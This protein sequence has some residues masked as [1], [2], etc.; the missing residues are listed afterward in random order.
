MPGTLGVFTLDPAG[1][2]T[3]PVFIQRLITGEGDGDG[4]DDLGPQAKHGDAG[5]Y[6]E[7]GH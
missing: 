5:F 2:Y 4:E 6:T 3:L 7:D 1:D